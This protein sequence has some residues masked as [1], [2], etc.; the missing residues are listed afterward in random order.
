MNLRPVSEILEKTRVIVRLDTDVPIDNNDQIL[1]NNRLIKSLPTLKILIEKKCKIAIIGHLGRPNET[2]K[3]K[4]SLKPV[5]LELISLLQNQNPSLNSIFIE[6][7]DNKERI[8]LS[9]VRNDLIFFENLRFYPEEEAGDTNFLNKLIEVSQ[10]FVNDAFATAHRP[11]ASVIIHRLLPS[12][13]GQNFIDE[14]TQL[15]KI[16][17]CTKPATLILGGAKEDKLKHLLKLTNIFDHVLI[18]GRLPLLISSPSDQKIIVASLI[19]DTF[20]ISPDS[21]SCFKQ[22]IG[23]SKTIV[24]I[25]AMGNFENGYQIGTNEIA[26]ALI[27][28]SAYKI[29]AGGDTTTSIKNLNIQDKIDYICS[30]GGVLLEYLATHTLPAIT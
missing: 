2:N 24:W 7:F 5:Y 21:I 12:F 23:Q 9:Y 8:D 16:D 6:N 13:Y 20:D 26:S 14:F 22:I 4:F 15:Q 19:P 11:H 3:S 30:G 29:V 27:N 17:S 25:G 10:F 28:S 1:N 18:G